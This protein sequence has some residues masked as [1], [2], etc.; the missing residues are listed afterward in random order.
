M[1]LLRS[2]QPAIP[3]SGAVAEAK[4]FTIKAKVTLALDFVP[5][6]GG[7]RVSMIEIERLR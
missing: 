3:A 1:S 5:G 7:P 2:F 4:A 6:S